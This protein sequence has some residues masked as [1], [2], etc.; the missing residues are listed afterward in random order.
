MKKEIRRKSRRYLKKYCEN[1][2]STKNLTIHHKIPLSQQFNNHPS[3]CMT[4]CINCHNKIHKIKLKTKY[5]SK[6][7]KGTPK[8]KRK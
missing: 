8:N 4:L 1:C 7:Q 5:P 2:G 6:Y 3:N